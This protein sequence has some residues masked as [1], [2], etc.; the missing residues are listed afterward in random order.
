MSITFDVNKKALQSMAKKP[1]AVSSIDAAFNTRTKSTVEAWGANHSQVIGDLPDPSAVDF[2]KDMSQESIAKYGKFV[3]EPA[4]FLPHALMQAIHQSYAEHYPLVLTPDSIWL[5]IAQGFGHHVN[6]N[7]E[8]LRKRFVQHE[9]KQM[10]LIHRNGFIKGNPNNDWAGCFTEFSDGIEKH[11]GKKRQ[12]IVGDFSTTGSIEKAASELVLMDAMKSYFKYAVRTLC[13]IP[14]VTLTGT[15]DDWRSIRTRAENLAEYDLDWWVK[16]LL[17]VLDKFV[18][19]AEG[20]PDIQFWDSLYKE[21][22]GSGG[23]YCNG[24]CNVFFPYLEGRRG[25]LTANKNLEKSLDT[26]SHFGTTMDQY[27]N[28]LSKVAFKWEMYGEVTYD[29]EF[30]GGLVGVH[31]DEQSL[32]LEP[33]V[34]WAVRDTGVATAGV[35]DPEEDW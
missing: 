10:I 27:P 29:M 7:A 26:K 3:P 1:L 6:A 34:G 21:S 12:L 32:A 14:S 20:N 17:P 11:I 33:I 19:T 31:Q 16:P 18:A 24:W 25:V 35:I 13:G 9:G 5:T 8:T 30:L 28:S 15:V 22:G 4:A 23:P 2:L